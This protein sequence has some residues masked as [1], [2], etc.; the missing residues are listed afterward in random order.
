MGFLQLLKPWL[1]GD[2]GSVS[3][4]EISATLNLTQGTIKM[5]IHRMRNDFGKGRKK[6]Q[7]VKTAS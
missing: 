3:R 1:M 7:P 6:R 5:A 4:E 2:E